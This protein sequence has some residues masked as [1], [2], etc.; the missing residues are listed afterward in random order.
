MENR[1]TWQKKNKNVLSPPHNW[2]HH[3][4]Q[5]TTWT[6]ASKEQKHIYQAEES[7]ILLAF[8]LIQHTAPA[9]LPLAF[10]HTL[11]F[12]YS[13]TVTHMRTHTVCEHTLFYGLLFYRATK[14]LAAE[15]VISI[16]SA[17]Q[18]SQLVI[19]DN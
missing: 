5:Q 17:S 19:E 2:Q 11:K 16:W 4:Q 10:I 1:E 13:S 14:Q 12:P 18:S 3:Q 6:E 8:S 15:L 7:I 9:P